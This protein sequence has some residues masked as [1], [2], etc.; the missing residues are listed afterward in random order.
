VRRGLA[1]LLCALAL[2]PAAAA[3]RA[4]A[5][6]ETTTTYPVRGT[7]LARLRAG[8]NGGPQGY[9]AY[10]RWF[11]KWNYD[12]GGSSSRCVLSSSTVNLRV[13]FTYP[14]WKDRA[15]ASPAL[16]ARWDRFMRAL[17]LHENGHKQNGV[18]AA[19][20]VNAL[21]GRA[22]SAGSC[23]ALGASVNRRADAAIARWAGA[24][25]TYDART[26]HGTTQGAIL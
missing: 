6:R 3:T 1:L 24:D 17:K 11:V 16:R 12:Y 4:P 13:V 8:I 23:T 18:R 25:K 10:T 21:L 19:R 14:S 15:K 2:V 5:Y 7:T 26:D 9:A 20:D 22:G